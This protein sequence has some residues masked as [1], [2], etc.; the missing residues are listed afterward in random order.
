[1]TRKIIGVLFVFAAVKELFSGQF[2]TAVISLI[3]TALLF[4]KEILEL[5]SIKS[6]SKSIDTIPDTAPLGTFTFQLAG[7]THNC[8]FPDGSLSRVTTISR[9]RVGDTVMLRQYEWEGKPAIAVISPRARNYDIGV[10]PA[11]KVS[12][13]CK[14]MDHYNTA[15]KIVSIEPFQ[16]RGDSYK[17]CD[18]MIE[19]YERVTE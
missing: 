15:A 18:V 16:Y 17:N 5:I 12:T 4:R 6:A 2:S 19:Y 9:S 10:V 7:V 3:I 1:M 14:L 11:N 8:R 13:V